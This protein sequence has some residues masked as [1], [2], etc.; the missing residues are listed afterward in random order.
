ME[1]AALKIKIIQKIIHTDNIEIL[2]DIYEILDSKNNLT[3][4]NEPTTVYERTEQKY[5]LNELQ[6]ARIEIALK[7]VANGEVL[8]EEEAETEMK[9]WLEEEEKLYGQ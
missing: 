2:M 9:K 8:T 6:K 4:I 7:Q 3:Q 1:N 5:V